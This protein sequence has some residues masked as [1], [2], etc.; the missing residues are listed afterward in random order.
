MVQKQWLSL[1]SKKNKFDL[2]SFVF[3]FL[4]LKMPSQS[5]LNLIALHKDYDLYVEEKRVFDRMLLLNFIIDYTER[6][7]IYWPLLY[8]EVV[9][10]QREWYR[11]SWI[12]I[13]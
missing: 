13:T 9:K 8:G 10:K 5:D 2:F 7:D 1:V 3:F 6:E 11:R 12:S 4:L